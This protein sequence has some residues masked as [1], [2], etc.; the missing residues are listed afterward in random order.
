[1]RDS[2]RKGAGTPAV[3]IAFAETARSNPQIVQ[4][5]AS[6]MRSTP[7]ER[8]QLVKDLLRLWVEG[9]LRYEEARTVFGDLFKQHGTKPFLVSLNTAK[10]GFTYLKVW[11]DLPTTISAEE[12]NGSDLLFSVSGPR[13]S[14]DAIDTYLRLVLSI[15]PIRRNTLKN[16]ARIWINWGA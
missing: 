4:I 6:L 1:V 15:Y 13:G 8:I 7:A 16:G 2:P 12:V 11:Y 9:K 3:T 5:N 10:S 14:E